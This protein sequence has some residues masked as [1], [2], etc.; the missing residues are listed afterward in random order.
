MTFSIKYKPLFSVNIL[1]KYYLNNGEENFFEMDQTE[2][3]K[4]LTG[5]DVLNFLKIIPTAESYQTLKNHRMVFKTINTGFAVWIQVTEYQ[6]TVPLISLDNSQELSF[7]LTLVNHTFI[8]FTKLD[9]SNTGKLFFFSNRKPEG[10]DASFPLIRKTNST[11]EV[12]DSYTLNTE[13]ANAF[14]SDLLSD[15]KRQLFGIVRI[16]MK[17]ENTSM[18]II[19]NQGEIHNP[20]KEFQMV[21]G[22][23]ETIW[24][25]F[26][27]KDQQVKNKDDVKKEN[28]SARQL[29]TKKTHPLTNT[30][31]VSIELG[32]KELPNPS[33]SVIK[34]DTSD[35]KIYSEIYM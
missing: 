22:N 23:R 7:L 16:A 24:R 5:Y 20:T 35:N 10:E 17:G 18:D 6:D 15:E 32:G 28:G 27:E 2:R 30:G 31:F 26:F 4:R 12:N 34:P 14:K 19:N 33:V 25:Y 9:A 3:D 29:I 21:L 8:N 1:H 11:Q 13:V